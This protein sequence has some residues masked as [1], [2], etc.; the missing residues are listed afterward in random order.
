MPGGSD[1]LGGLCP[2]V[3]MEGVTPQDWHSH[4]SSE[5]HSRDRH[6]VLGQDRGELLGCCHPFCPTAES[7]APQLDALS[8]CLD[9]MTAKSRDPV[10]RSSPGPHQPLR[11]LLH[12]RF[13]QQLALGQVPLLGS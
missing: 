12:S 6:M 4:A 13:A 3:G 2:L 8:L 7:T 11:L 10:Q 9:T 5:G 1:T